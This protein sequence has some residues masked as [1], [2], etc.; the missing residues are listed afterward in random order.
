MSSI[1][2]L[3]CQ[4][5]LN[6][7]AMSKFTCGGESFDAFSGLGESINKASAAGDVGS[8]PIPPG[9][10][11]I[12]DRQ[13]GGKLGWFRDF[14]SGADKW[15]ALYAIDGKIDDTAY[16]R[17][18]KRGEFRLHPKGPRGLSL[19]CVVIDQH[20]DFDRLRSMLLSHGSQSVV[21]SDLKAFGILT[22]T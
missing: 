19:G 10:Y 21:G 4:F 1:D 5:V 9:K 22:V 3:Q 8:G 14:L 15:F 17:D 7:K 20:A 6:G 18:V 13:S 16:F 11:Y 12:F 2:L